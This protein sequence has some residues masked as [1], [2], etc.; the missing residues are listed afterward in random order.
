MALRERVVGPIITIDEAMELAIEIQIKDQFANTRTLTVAHAPY[1]ELE[2][3]D[4]TPLGLLEEIGDLLRT[5]FKAACTGYGVGVTAPADKDNID[6]FLD[7]TP[8][9][10]INSTLALLTL[11]DLGDTLVSGQP[12][13]P[14]YVKF[15][16][17]SDVWALIGMLE[18][19][20]AADRTVNAVFGT[21][22]I[23]DAVGLWQPPSVFCFMR[24]D[25]T[26][27][28][29][30]IFRDTFT[31]ELRDGKVKSTVRG[32]PTF[33]DSY[34]IVDQRSTIVGPLYYVGEFDSVK[35]NRKSVYLRVAMPSASR[36]NQPLYRSDLLVSGRYYL[37]GHSDPFLFRLNGNVVVTSTKVE[38]PLFTKVPTLLATPPTKSPVFGVPEAIALKM[39][40]LMNGALWI[41]GSDPATGA[42]IFAGSI[43]SI[44]GAGEV[45]INPERRDNAHPFYSLMFDLI[46]HGFP[47]VVR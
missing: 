15:K 11:D 29:V 19:A 31:T 21:R 3:G 34:K 22:W 17:T 24:A 14:D 33:R 40:A 7:W 30:P 46:L 39:L 16:N 1:E 2:A 43:Y 13:L 6:L 44:V 23:V 38:L 37:V 45:D 12:A 28:V 27:G 42:P 10:G 47:T 36:H 8:A 9:S 4:Y 5:W 35:A 18:A 41:G 20:A 25:I 26:R 32:G